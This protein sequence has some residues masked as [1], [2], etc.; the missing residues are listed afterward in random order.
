VLAG[1]RG[2]LRV[3]LL[4]LRADDSPAEIARLA[5]RIRAHNPVQPLFFLFAGP[6]Y[7]RLGFASFG[8]GGELRQLVID[9]SQ[10]RRSDV[11]TLEELAA[12]EGEGSVELLHRHGR[13]LDRTRLT[14]QFFRDFRAQRDRIAAAWTGIPEEC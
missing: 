2:G 14:H 7:R 4:E 3:L 8:I 12:R 10:I 11:E 13:A 5:R 1:E 9:R 6:R